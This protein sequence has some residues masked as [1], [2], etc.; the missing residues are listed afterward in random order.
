VLG[1]YRE[2]LLREGVAEVQ[3]GLMEK[4]K[5]KPAKEA[6]AAKSSSENAP[7]CKI[8]QARHWGREPHSFGKVK[9]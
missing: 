9:R 8:C 3:G 1:R 5:P 7:F 2:G 4:K 6:R